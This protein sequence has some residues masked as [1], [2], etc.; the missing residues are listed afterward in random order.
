MIR[1]EMTIKKEKL[2]FLAIC[3]I[4]VFLIYSQSLF[5][6]FVFDDRS[7]VEHQTLLENPNNLYKII[8]LPYWTEEAGLYR[9]ITLLSYAF[10]Y[11]F[12]GFKPWHFHLVNLILYAL[13]GYLLFLL[14]KKLFPEKKLLFYLAPVLFLVLPI[15]TE[16]V[17]NIVGRAEILA[18]FFSL[19]VFLEIIKKKINFWKLVFWLVLALGSK[20]IAIA[21]W[22]ISLL[23]IYFKNSKVR[24]FKIKSYLLTLLALFLAASVYFAAR[25]LVLGQHFFSNSATLVE[26]PLKFAPFWPRIITSL[27][28]LV[29]YFKKSF[30]PFQLCSDYSY[31]QIPV[32]NN[33]FNL[34]TLLGLFILLFFLI[35]LVIFWKRNPILSLA[36]SFFIFGFL[37]ISNLIV[38]IGTIAGERLI[39][40]SSV[41]LTIFLAQILIY[42]KRIRIVFFASLIILICFYSG[43]SFIRNFDWLTEKQLFISAGQ[44]ASQSVL[45]RSNLGTVYYL[46]NNYEQAEKEFLAAEEIYPLYSKAINN[47]GLIYWKKKEYN[48]AKEQ[49]F[50]AIKNWPAYLGVYENLALLEISQGK[51]EK[52]RKWLILGFNSKEMADNFL[53]NYEIK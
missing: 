40:Y 1:L 47:L 13:T 41:G 12:F 25:F 21:A 14:L 29:I 35:S 38:P 43:V 3:F 20:E 7:I 15:H 34:E 28:V 51:I 49:Y 4:L 5:G 33:F 46:D 18:L 8:S 39:Y 16:V 45:S 2:V 26:N 32:L 42:L 17:A 9:P 24:L 50:K 27:K 36:S 44:C 19:L 23:I 37:P 6:D 30:W 10:N 52:A 22:P 11:S 48:K 31:N 53:K